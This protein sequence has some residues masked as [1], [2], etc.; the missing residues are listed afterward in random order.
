VFPALS[1]SG[2]LGSLLDQVIRICIILAS[3][4]AFFGLGFS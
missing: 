2:K 1:N 3:V 4:L